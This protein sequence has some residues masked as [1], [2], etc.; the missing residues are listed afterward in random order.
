MVE[1]PFLRPTAMAM[2][3]GG[4]IVHVDMALGGKGMVGVGPSGGAVRH[5][6]RACATLQRSWP[7]TA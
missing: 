7:I 6:G 5:R 2:G 1:A 3:G 4:H